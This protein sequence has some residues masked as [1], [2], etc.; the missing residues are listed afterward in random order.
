[1]ALIDIQLKQFRWIKQD[2]A[3]VYQKLDERNEILK[4]HDDDILESTG[5]LKKSNI[6]CINV[7][8]KLKTLME[9]WRTLIS[10]I[11]LKEKLALVR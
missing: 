8:K 1:M 3:D 10:S 2:I 5:Y 4:T 7:I 11:L 6:L 9:K